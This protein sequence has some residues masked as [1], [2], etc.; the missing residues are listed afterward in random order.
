MIQYFVSNSFIFSG[1]VAGSGDNPTT[2]TK[3]I[4]TCGCARPIATEQCARPAPTR[5]LSRSS[6]GPRCSGSRCATPGS[7]SATPRWC[8]ASWD[9][10]ISTFTSTLTRGL[11]TMKILYHGL[12]TGRSHFSARE[13]KTVS[14]TVQLG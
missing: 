4:L 5:A 6:T 13:K 11:S 7:R 8:A 10:V 1:L 3:T 14:R 2:A 12:S 9:S